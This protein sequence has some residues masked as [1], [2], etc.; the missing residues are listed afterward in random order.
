MAAMTAREF[1]DEIVEPTIREFITTPDRRRGYLACIVSY[2]LS[3]YLS[4]T[5]SIDAKAALG[6]PFVAL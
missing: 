3:D 2:H 4:P 1:A 5:A 6:L